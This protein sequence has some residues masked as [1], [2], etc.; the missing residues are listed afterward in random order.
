MKT[1]KKSFVIFATIMFLLISGNSF[2]QKKQS[3]F[4]IKG[5]PLVAR[6]ISDLNGADVDT[7]SKFGFAVFAF[8]DF[9]NSKSIVL[10]GEVGFDQK[11]YEVD[12]IDS[13]TTGA[14]IKSGN[15]KD[16]LNYLDISANFKY[17]TRGKSASPYFSLTPTLGVY[18]GHSS[19]G[20]VTGDSLYTNYSADAIDS[21]NSIS[22]SIKIGLGVELYNIIKNVPVIFEARYNPDLTQAYNTNNYNIRNSTVEFNLGVKF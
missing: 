3:N 5:G 20:S 10:S 13:D 6:I 16:N 21:L 19:S 7:K 17:I 18:L 9:Y 1:I 15:L 4:G 11:G 22:F 12:V 14:V 8:Y 2:A